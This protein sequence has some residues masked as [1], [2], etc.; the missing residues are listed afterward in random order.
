MLISLFGFLIDVIII[1][2]IIIIIITTTTK[3]II[4]LIIITTATTTTTIIIIIIII[5][6]ILVVQSNELDTKMFF[7]FLFSSE[8]EHDNLEGRG[9]DDKRNP[10][11]G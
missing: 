7:L 5:I 3:I 10:S 11:G 9:T 4:I 6:D 8:T 1:I 2:I